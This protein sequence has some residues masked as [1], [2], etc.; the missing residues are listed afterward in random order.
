MTHIKLRTVF[1]VD[2]N[3]IVTDEVL[4]IDFDYR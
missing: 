3:V 1:T 2:I 4:I